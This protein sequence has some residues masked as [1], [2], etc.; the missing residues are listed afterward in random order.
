MVLIRR[1]SWIPINFFVLLA[2]FTFLVET[3][4]CFLVKCNITA[5]LKQITSKKLR[6]YNGLKLTSEVFE[7]QL[8]PP[9]EH[10]YVKFQE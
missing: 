9:P 4:A 2:F 8:I 7:A 5:I 3:L 10:T 1:N 6:K